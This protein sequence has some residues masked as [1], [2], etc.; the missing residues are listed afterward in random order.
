MA[1][2]NELP[3]ILNKNIETK[4][5]KEDRPYNKIKGPN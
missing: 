5:G 4:N 2:I 1:G 3:A